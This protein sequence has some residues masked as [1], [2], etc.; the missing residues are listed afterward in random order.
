ML[1]HDCIL[2]YVEIGPQTLI[3]RRVMLVRGVDLPN[4]IS[5]RYDSLLRA[6]VSDG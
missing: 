4:N 5:E 6:L 1:G 2:M 3:E